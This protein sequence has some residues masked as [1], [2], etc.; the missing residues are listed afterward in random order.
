MSEIP[1]PIPEFEPAP[2]RRVLYWLSQAG[3]WISILVVVYI[4][5]IV[6]LRMR[7]TAFEKLEPIRYRGD[8]QNAYM[9]GRNVIRLA[10]EQEKL[11]RGE[12]PTWPATFRAYLN[13][14]D[15]VQNGWPSSNYQ[16]DYPPMR[17][18]VMTA[19]SRAIY[20]P[21]E[22]LEPG[23][24]PNCAIPLRI[25]IGAEILAS[26]A[27]LLLVRHW[28]GRVAPPRESWRPMLCGATAAVLMWLNLGILIDAHGWPQWDVW[29]VPF[30]LFTMYAASVRRWMVAGLIYGFGIMF[31][32][33]L[34]AAA[35]LLLL[36]PIFSADWSGFWRFTN[37]WPS[38]PRPSSAGDSIPAA[39]NTV[40]PAWRQTTIAVLL[41]LWRFVRFVFCPLFSPAWN[42]FGR[43][44]AGLLTSVAGIQF[45]WLTPIPKACWLVAGFIVL[46]IVLRIVLRRWLRGQHAALI[47]AC[48]AWVFVT[49]M[50]FGV[51]F[52]WVTRGF[53]YGAERNSDSMAAPGA[54]NLG[55]LLRDQFGW[56][57]TDQIVATYSLSDEPPPPPK[58]IDPPRRSLFRWNRRPAP[59]PPVVAA[60]RGEP[61]W[62]LSIGQL[63]KG[64][65]G[66]SLV[67]CA[68]A[69]AVHTRRDDPRALAAIAAPWLLFYGLMPQ[70]SNRYSLWGAAVTALLAGVGVGSVLLHLLLSVI[71]AITIIHVMILYSHN[72]NWWPAFHEFMERSQSGFAWV[73]LLATAVVLYLALSPSRGRKRANEMLRAS[74]RV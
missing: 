69:L 33:Q 16:L 29:L 20:Q 24:W 51:S 21:G 15:R 70:M 5:G 13:F 12:I 41:W 40:R 37:R 58:K 73:S 34:L 44:L 50:I 46:V 47:G 64:M 38:A 32:G 63:M 19:W 3:A 42:N 11:P 65:F 1:Y 26:L 23:D 27:A 6:G 18:F 53:M 30:Y 68:I 54:Y 67:L 14:Y 59:P 56:N 25:N 36:W 39:G 2:R 52:A 7:E 62:T 48:G 74:D 66:V 28:V 49:A 4:A 45:M 8:L 35:P 43:L 22:Q 9:H 57:D 17:L 61:I 71:S 60:P 55:S 31:K 10:R 72:Y